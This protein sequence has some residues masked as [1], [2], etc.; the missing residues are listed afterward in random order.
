[1]SGFSMEAVRRIAELER[2][3]ERLKTQEQ[4]RISHIINGG[5]P[6]NT[7][8]E[9]RN[10]DDAEWD[11]SVASLNNTIGTHAGGDFG[12]WTS[13]N[14]ESG[15]GVVDINGADDEGQL[16][17]LHVA[18]ERTDPD[19]VLSLDIAAIPA[20]TRVEFTVCIR[21]IFPFNSASDEYFAIRV[22]DVTESTYL[23]VFFRNDGGSPPAMEVGTAYVDGGSYTVYG[24]TVG[25]A[26]QG[27][28]H[29]L[30]LQW[31]QQTNG[32][33][34]GTFSMDGHL[35]FDFNSA[36]YTFSNTFA[37]N[38][39]NDTLQ[40]IMGNPDTGSDLYNIYRLDSFRRT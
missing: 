34:R 29:A 21:W 27:E 3:L 28:P 37:P 5:H 17:H 4:N 8:P 38:A 16:S 6:L 40:L 23:E 36:A 25:F 14:P 2:E 12:Q 20:S 33:C 24:N 10:A 13:G 9:A 31:V 19:A 22:T 11:N 18:V 39:G 35:F 30:W 1:M 26:D 7:Y 32:L 15:S